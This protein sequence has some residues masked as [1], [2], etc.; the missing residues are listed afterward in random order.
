METNSVKTES[1]ASKKTEKAEKA[2]KAET[3]KSEISEKKDTGKDSSGDAAPAEV[4]SD[5]LIKDQKDSEE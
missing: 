4:Q 3:Q 5:T 1:T 2:E